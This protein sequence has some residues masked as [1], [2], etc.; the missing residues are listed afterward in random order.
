MDNATKITSGSAAILAIIAIILSSG[1]IGQSDVFA[2]EDLGI[3]MQCGEGLSNVN[4][5]GL[6]TRCK[7]FSEELN[8]STYK[9]CNTGWLPY[10]P[11]KKYNE[12]FNSSKEHIY[13]F[14]EKNNKFVSL[15]QIVDGNETIYKVES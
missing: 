15:C 4:A 9:N 10:T 2:C 3:A 6:Q 11:E 12:D 5:D 8:R 14:C 13:L 1:L 7:Y